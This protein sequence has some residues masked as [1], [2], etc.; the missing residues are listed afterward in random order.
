MVQRST[1]LVLG[2]TGKT[3]THFVAKALEDGH[4]VRALVRTPAKLEGRP[5]T[6]D[7][8]QGSITDDLD[9]DALVD[10]CDYVVSML[11]DRNL[12]Q[13]VM[14]NTAFVKKLVPSMRR[15]GVKR[16]LCQAGGLSTPY[17][18]RL[19]PLLWTIRHT[20]ARSFLG[21]HRDNE[22]VMAYFATEANDIEWIV[23][24]AGIGSDGPSKGVLQRSTSRPSV[25]THRDCA[26]YNYHTVTDASAVRTADFS[27]YVS[28][29]RT[30]TG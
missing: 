15:K 27:R 28:A 6:L 4:T 16:F 14:I 11:G 2:A 19:S 22:A 29:G 10:G 18:G 5:A 25:A 20:L 21:Q 12:Q 24:R 26:T 3:G 7:V 30:A 9:M 23:H 1:F 13:T 8:R 17:G